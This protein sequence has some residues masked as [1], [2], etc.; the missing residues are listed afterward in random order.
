MYVV[1]NKEAK[2]A[3]GEMRG[4]RLIPGVGSRIHLTPQNSTIAKQ[5][6]NFA[7]HHLYVS[8]QKDSEARSSFPSN[9]HERDNPFVDFNKFFDGESL[10]QQDL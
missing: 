5:S 10:D 2:N 4:Y 7:T 8:R 6:A 9:S 1:V 3:Y